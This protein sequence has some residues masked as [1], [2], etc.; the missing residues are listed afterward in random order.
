MSLSHLT[1][2]Q[3]YEI[4]SNELE[5]IRSIYMD[6]FV[7]L[8][9]KK[10]GWDKQPQIIFEIS[11][12]SGEK[13]PVES[14]LTLH[15]ALTPMYP[16]T[17]PEITFK[18][19]ENVLDSQ[20]QSLV[21]EY[22][23]IHRGARG[24]EFIFD[25]ATSTQEKLDEFQRGAN[26]Q[27]LEDD[28]LQRIKET[29][30]KLER[31]EMESQ[32]Q[33]EKLKISEQQRIDEIVQKELEKR[34]DDDDMFFN[35]G[36]QINFL[37]PNEWISSGEAIV[38]P[39]IIKAKLP[40]N[41]LL[42]FKAV[43]NPKEVKI[44][45]DLLCFAKQYL[46]KPYISPDSP[47]AESLMSS[48]VMENFYF[49]MTEVELDNSYFN[50]SN[51]KKEISHFEKIL[52]SL[53]K[54]KHDNVNQ[55]YG[56]LVERMGK[57]NSTFVWKIKFLSEYSMSYPLGDIVQSVGFIN[58]ATARIW[59]IRL[60]E[61]LE[62]L[63]KL[64]VH[65][66]CIGLQTVYLVKD[67]DFG[68]T[69]P[70]IVY[71]EYGYMLVNMLTRYPN[72]HGTQVELPSNP[73]TA[74]ESSNYKNTKSQRMTDIWQLGVLF[75]QM[76]NGV[77][78]V[79]DYSTPLDFMESNDMESSLSDFLEKMLNVDPKR[80]LGPLEL[81]PMK[82]LRTNIDSD[83]NKLNL[84]PGTSST[85][86]N[87]MDIPRSTPRALSHSSSGRR[88]FNVGSR[89][90]S[91]N[92]S[93]RSRYATDFEE[94]A[95]LGKGAFGQVVKARNT[96]DSRYY[97]VKK[98]RHTEEKLSTI[99]S[100]VMLLASLNH[101]YVVRYY[102][103]WLEEDYLNENVID[104][105][106]EDDT[107]D[108]TEEAS[109]TA[110]ASYSESMRSKQPLHNSNWDFISNS[111]YPEIEFGN[112]STGP[113]ITGSG[114][115]DG[116]VFENSTEEGGVGN[117]EDSNSEDEKDSPG[118][119]VGKQKKNSTFRKSVGNRKSILFIQMEYCENRTLYDLIHAENLNNER[120]GYW[121][122]FRQILEALSYIH[123]QGI[124]HRDL[125]PMNI[126]IDES[127]NVKIGDFGLAK[128]VQRPLDI[129][130]LDS[131]TAQ[132]STDNL[133]SAIGTALYVAV[134]VLSGKGNYNEKIDMYSL[135]IIFFEMVYPFS[136]GMERV[137]I[138]KNL[139][140][141]T[142]E[143]PRDFD[144][145][146]MKTE[147]KI[148]TLLLD[149]DPNKRPAARALL[150]SGWLPVK[151]QDEVIKEALKSL[152]NPSS[153]WQQQVRDSLFTQSYS[154]S[155]DILFDNV[156]SATTRFT[157]VLRS[158]MTEEVVKIFRKHGGIENNAPSRIFP[159]AP[160]YSTQNVYEVL[161]HG[162]SVLQLQYDLTYPMARY[163]SKNPPCVSKQF[164]LQF[165]YRPP[166]QL[167]SSMEPRKFGEID[168]DIVSSS[169]AQSPFY[170][171]ES[172]KIID[173]ILTTFPVFEK[174]NTLFVL[175]HADIL[176][177][178]FD[179]SNIDK[180]QRP[181]ISRMLSQIGFAKSFKEVK[182]ELKSQLNIPS[183]SLNDLDLF[184]FK[185]DFETAKR[186]FHKVMV[187]SP[188][189]RK[190][191]ES[192]VHISKV[193]NFLKPLDVTRN[194]V[195]SPLS[196]YNSAFYKG[197]I[198]YQA[199][200]DDGS[201]RSLIAAGG[202]YDN[203]I[204]Y[205]ARPSG[206][207]RSSTKRA[208][209]FNLAWET[210]FGVA[211]SYFKLA[212][213]NKVKKRNKFLKDGAIEWKPRR[214]DILISSFSNSILETMGVPMLN[215][216]WKIGIKADL[217]F[218][219]YT[220][221]DVVS[222]AKHDGVDWIVLIKQQ[223]Y[224]LSNHKRKYKPLK[225]KKMSSD[226]DVDLDI[227][228]FLQLYEH[229]TEGSGSFNVG[230]ALPDK[231]D[232]FGYGEDGSSASSSHEGDPQN[233]EPTKSNQKVIYVPNMATRSKKANKREKWVYEDS[234]RNASNAIINSLTQAPVIT[235]DAIRDETLEIISITSLAQKE[236]WLRKVFGSVNNSSPRSF[237]TSIYNSLSKEAAKGNKWAI[238]HCHKTGKS[239]VIDLQR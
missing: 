184:D 29:T 40:N 140:S 145:T 32:R 4:Q 188:Y 117:T 201:N 20:L 101:Q 62:A 193:L 83:V 76:I 34:Q 195:I 93:S 97:A 199:V 89:F 33:I 81:L 36:N 66:A 110:S 166:E 39:K 109:V 216:L 234:A 138:L 8:T 129:S 127:R 13:D 112:S 175:N 73:W 5:A 225:V 122:L 7:D 131:A 104:S 50:T 143:F 142:V 43:V 42:K 44:S 128:N 118:L 18:N 185:L 113:N 181:L 74:P 232:E 194:V 223:T 35:S 174:G 160:I 231:H 28:R 38:F 218:D 221:D 186:R 211:Q 200:Y 14:S 87:S 205:F 152:S 46:V 147:R 60:L 107:E 197:G 149:H 78:T 98:I 214:C 51:G 237:A 48:E 141:P 37:P 108:D 202:R 63:H 146:K 219:C 224:T 173:E 15:I 158:Q 168:F 130:K 154:L 207:K 213:G 132:R 24:Q 111:G 136:T 220:V 190:I 238:L 182:A 21:D 30:E 236:E 85:E 54:V 164:R 135:G 56:Y 120:D 191:D 227:H 105:S 88:S 169:S 209:G 235:V 103:A 49:L 100:E 70:K 192:L 2:D 139:R 125:K 239:C 116:I 99:L 167:K 106:D 10:S 115:S 134:E 22:K 47:L 144:D 31:E 96:L 203:L 9:R 156:Q 208:V 11:L 178:V 25:I 162:G 57:N 52:D 183:I 94:I 215:Q 3:Y 137:N 27:S 204:S 133:T 187:D 71:P 171:A 65:H 165:V 91:M 121:R 68:T 61:G 102:A 228:E 233:E 1:L 58:L 95:V 176:E 196:N 229:E 67:P 69:I 90:S 80:R 72:R 16:H 157:Q 6:D 26:P 217:L 17:T 180:A 77:N 119:R 82:F 163:L 179:F 12:R 64:G 79:L 206:S 86:L 212:S 123:S 92:R 150:N 222:A 189:L 210:I 153:P 23:K 53:L 155:N 170:D 177:S 159:K 59:M 126:F 124:I 45:S 84:L 226:L 75:I 19:V 151:H 161:D 198:M 148:I 55:L 114:V 172:I 230:M 41:S